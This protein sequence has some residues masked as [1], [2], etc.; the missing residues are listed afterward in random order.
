MLFLSVEKLQHTLSAKPTKKSPEEEVDASRQ[1]VSGK[2]APVGK[3]DKL[4]VF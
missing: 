1:V 3:D 4:K 2:S